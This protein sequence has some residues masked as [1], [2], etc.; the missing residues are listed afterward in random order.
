MYESGFDRDLSVAG[1]AMVKTQD[2]SIV[3]K[4]VR[5][6]RPSKHAPVPTV[7]V[8]RHTC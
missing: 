8:I 3:Q 1:R 2:G 4:L 6:D 5:I 7:A